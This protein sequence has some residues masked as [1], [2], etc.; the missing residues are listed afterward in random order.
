MN[1]ANPAKVK[2][3]MIYADLPEIA[4]A[5]PSLPSGVVQ[6]KPSLP[7]FRKSTWDG[8]LI[9][10]DDCKAILEAGEIT[11][12]G[13]KFPVERPKYSR[14]NAERVNHDHD[15]FIVREKKEDRVLVTAGKYLIH[16]ELF[17]GGHVQAVRPDFAVLCFSAGIYGDASPLPNAVDSTN[18]DSLLVAEVAVENENGNLIDAPADIETPDAMAE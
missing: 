11:L 8:R 2:P 18:P 9:T 3:T 7:E 10:L 16:S 15:F 12:N 4:E 6:F 1:T 13:E 14:Y 5:I 17:G